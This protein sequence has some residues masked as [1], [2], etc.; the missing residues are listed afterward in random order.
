MV[1]QR[2]RSLLEAVT[3]GE[4]KNLTGEVKNAEELFQLSA[5]ERLDARHEGIYA[6][7]LFDPDADRLLYSY[8]VDGSIINDTGA[9]ILVLFERSRIARTSAATRQ[10]VDAGID[11]ASEDPMVSFARALF[12][13]HHIALP[14]IVFTERLSKN[15]DCVFVPL[16]GET[17]EAATANIRRTLAVAS[18]AIRKRGE[19]GGFGEIIGMAFAGADI[20][21]IHSADVPLKE[22][23]LRALRFLWKARRD[24]L[25]LVPVIGKVFSAKSDEKN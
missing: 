8:L 20:A 1:A 15:G 14:S 6:I 25:A 24:L 5:L 4:G 16:K 23:M 18:S 13:Q 17:R 7:V 3:A 21:C 2:F 10:S 12:P 22:S 19:V 9:E 11:I